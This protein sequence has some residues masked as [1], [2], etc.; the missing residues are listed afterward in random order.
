MR[1]AS[2]EFSVRVPPHLKA[3]DYASFVTELLAH[4]DPVKVARQK[5]LEERITVPFRLAGDEDGAGETC[6]PTATAYCHCLSTFDV[7]CSRFLS[8]ATATAIKLPDPPMIRL[9]KSEKDA[10]GHALSDVKGEVF[11]YGSRTDI[12]KKGG[13]IDILIL[14][15]TELPHKLAQDVT[16]RFR[17]ECDEKIDVTVVNPKNISEEQKPFLSLIRRQAVNYHEIK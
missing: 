4:A 13:D 6:W 10:L 7:Q 2:E 16:V 17:M 9:L 5:A 11:L 12:G 8:P 15:E 1:G 14:S 3:D